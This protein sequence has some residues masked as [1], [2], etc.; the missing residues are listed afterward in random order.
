[1]LILFP[2]DLKNLS[3]PDYKIIFEKKQENFD[4]EKRQKITLSKQAVNLY[5][6]FY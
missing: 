3:K 5:F 6:K 2:H 4:R 1:L